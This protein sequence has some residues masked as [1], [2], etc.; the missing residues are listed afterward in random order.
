MPMMCILLTTRHRTARRKWVSQY[1]GWMQSDW[2]QTM[3]MDISWFTLQCDIRHALDN[4]RSHTARLVENFLEA[5][6]EASMLS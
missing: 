3:F 6:G 1:Q 2:S 4:V 5:Y